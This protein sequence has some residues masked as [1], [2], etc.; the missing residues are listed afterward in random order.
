[1]EYVGYNPPN[2]RFSAHL[3]AGQIAHPSDTQPRPQNPNGRETY[4]V[5][6][7]PRVGRAVRVS[8]PVHS[9][10]AGCNPYASLTRVNGVMDGS[11]PLLRL[12]LVT[13]MRPRRDRPVLQTELPHM[14]MSN[15]HIW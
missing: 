4:P 3:Q 1:M 8:V 9:M 7:A 2:P 13:S 10:G 5:P 6:L 12:D 11:A 15:F 14:E